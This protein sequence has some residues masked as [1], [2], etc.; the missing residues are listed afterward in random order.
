MLL[1]TLYIMRLIHQQG[2]RELRP[3]VKEEMHLQEKTLSTFDLD[4]G[5]KVT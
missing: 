5:V 1:S 3:T 2:L 4:L